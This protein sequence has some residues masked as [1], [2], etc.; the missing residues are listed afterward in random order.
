MPETIKKNL[1]YILAALFLSL[2]FTYSIY[3]KIYTEKFDSETISSNSIKAV[4]SI[5]K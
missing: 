1:N 4:I 2:V 5:H 3:G